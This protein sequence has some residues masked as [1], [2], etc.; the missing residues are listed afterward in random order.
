MK[1]DSL[2]KT[3]FVAFSIVLVCSLLV[4]GAVT[5]LRPIQAAQKAPQNFQRILQVAGLIK[6]DVEIDKQEN[7]VELFQQIEISI[8]DLNTA[9]YITPSASNKFDYRQSLSEPQSTTPLSKSADLANIERKPKQMPIYWVH[10]ST[11]KAKIVLPIYGKGMWSMIHGYIALERDFNTIAGVYFYEQADTPGIGEL[12]QQSDW[13]T[14]WQGKKLYD[15]NGN[16]ALQI[17][18]SKSSSKSTHQID[19]ITGATKTVNGVINLI[20]FW[21]GEQGYRSFLSKQRESLEG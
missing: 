14:S 10:S 16:L 12:I 9:S 2:G 4:T 15:A 18:K 5:L 11:S 17:N 20:H 8:L 19:G 7:M 13:S 3:L 1:R 21:F 6:Q